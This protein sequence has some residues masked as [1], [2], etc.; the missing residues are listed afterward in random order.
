MG[1][2]VNDKSKGLKYNKKSWDFFNF[3]LKFNNE[4]LIWFL[5]KFYP[6]KDL[7]FFKRLAQLY[8]FE[9]S[10]SSELNSLLEKLFNH[11][12]NL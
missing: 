8:W 7:A 4:F 1:F 3:W 6:T 9:T 12:K 5:L 11:Y 10:T 2:I